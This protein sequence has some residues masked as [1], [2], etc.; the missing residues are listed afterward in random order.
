MAIQHG[1][2][3]RGRERQSKGHSGVG[4]T[5]ILGSAWKS[6]GSMVV[7]RYPDSDMDVPTDG[8]VRGTETSPA[9]TGERQPV[10]EGQCMECTVLPSCST[11]QIRRMSRYSTVPYICQVDCYYA[12]KWKGPAIL[13]V[14]SQ[15]GRSPP[16][17]C[18]LIPCCPS[19]VPP[20]GR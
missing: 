18:A 1:E 3:Q 15:P 8:A 13:S 14:T 4:R 5:S 19:T 20:V 17:R 7:M 11:N 12:V 6:R 9:A 2:A 10:A 16:G